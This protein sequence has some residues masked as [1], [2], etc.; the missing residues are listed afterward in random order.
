MAESLRKRS[1]FA[2]AVFILA[3]VGQVVTENSVI[4]VLGICVSAGL[5]VY[6]IWAI[7]NQTLKLLLLAAILV[8][9]SILLNIFY[10]SN[11][12]KELAQNPGV[13]I[14]M[15]SEAPQT[16][17]STPRCDTMFP[18]GVT[19]KYRILYGRATMGLFNVVPH[20]VLRIQA[21]DN[22]FRN[23]LTLDV[24]DRGHLLVTGEFYDDNGDLLG[25]LDSN[26]FTTTNQSGY[27]KRDNRSHYAIYD[28]TGEKRFD[29]LFLDPVTIRITGR[30]GH[31]MG[32]YLNVTDNDVQTVLPSGHAI[33][34][35]GYC[36]WDR[37]GMKPDFWLGGGPDEQAPHT[38]KP[39]TTPKDGSGAKLPK[40][41]V[42][43]GGFSLTV[44]SEAGEQLKVG[45]ILKPD[46]T[47]KLYSSIVFQIARDY[48]PD[49]VERKKLENQLWKSVEDQISKNK[50]L[51]TV[52]PN[53]K[54]DINFRFEGPP[55]TEE[56]SNQVK[57]DHVVYIMTIA[58]DENRH[59][60]L[61]SC[62]HTKR[63]DPTQFIYC[64][65]H[66]S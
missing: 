42:S 17:L 39:T 34:L 26:R 9:F 45:V 57:T 27:S 59:R 22:T 21:N 55:L 20:I 8:G 19:M 24:N 18:D 32:G 52:P 6:S 35:K 3:V 58:V 33:S 65:D 28:R 62:I 53:P 64:I 63:N 30:I 60:L 38:P 50:K 14:P 37:D 43:I 2:I 54:N 1:T 44:P 47:I 7:E 5:F 10:H 49:Y 4:M 46:R 13:I 36:P 48:G 12:D 61:E 11:L 23:I 31:P 29:I 16:E 40:G 51:I 66:N 56:Q 15:Y 25:R 41:A